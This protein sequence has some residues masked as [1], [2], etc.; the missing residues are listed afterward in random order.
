MLAVSSGGANWIFV[1]DSGH[2]G[3]LHAFCE[4]LEG[5]P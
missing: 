3:N 4:A 2:S 1:A 5:T